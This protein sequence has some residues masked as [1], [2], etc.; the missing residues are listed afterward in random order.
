M[1]EDEDEGVL[2]D[3]TSEKG[4]EDLLDDQSAMEKFT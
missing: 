3:D 4:F 1:D 2:E